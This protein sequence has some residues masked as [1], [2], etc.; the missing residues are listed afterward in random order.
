MTES[1]VLAHGRAA[2]RRSRRSEPTQQTPLYRA[3]CI[4]MLPLAALVIGLSW[5]MMRAGIDSYRA[6][7]FLQ[8]WEAKGMPDAETLAA[9]RQAAEHA[10]ER[11]PA[12]NGEYL[13]RLGRVLSWEDADAPYGA[14]EAQASRQAALETYRASL[15]VRPGWPWTW[16][17]LTSTKLSQQA[18]DD[19]FADALSRSSALG[20]NRIEMDRDL[21]RIGF[22]GWPSLTTEQRVLTLKAAARTVG[23]SYPEAQNLYGLAQRAGLNVPLC[24]S[25]S[26]DI[27]A[28]RQ[29]CKKE[30]SS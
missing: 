3:I 8:S 10:I 25:L 28:K 21:A 22:E 2:K 17:R 12:P 18:F 9:G 16:L 30:G 4:G 29:I 6:E 14:A 20:A 1:P 19:E 15:A 27:R 24:W 7:R 13:D 23:Y 5:T 26:E 11:F